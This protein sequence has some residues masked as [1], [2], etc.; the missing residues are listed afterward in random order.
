MC[1]SMLIVGVGGQGTLLTSRI[2]GRL[3]MDAGYD[4]KMSEVHGMAQRGGSVVTHV[5]YGDKVYSP[6]IEP[7]QADFI[8]SFEKLEA[9]R[10]AHYL[11]PGG[12][13]LVNDQEIDPMSVVSGQARYPEDL[14]ERLNSRDASVVRVAGLDIARELGDLRVINLVLL[15]ALSLYLPEFTQES[16]ENA[17]QATVPPRTVQINLQAF[18]GGRESGTH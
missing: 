6:L 3:A 18:A 10:W 13:I 7:G 8:L 2:L 9:L 5:R 14:W 4:V 1:K 17:I 11:K 15:G 16:W 12:V